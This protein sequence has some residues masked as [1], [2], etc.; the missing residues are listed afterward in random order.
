MNISKNKY[1][2]SVHRHTG[3]CLLK[4]LWYYLFML[5]GCWN[6]AN[7]Y[8]LRGRIVQHNREQCL[9]YM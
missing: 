8:N 3:G 2:A 1:S 9:A 7:G 6:E 4:Y 5:V